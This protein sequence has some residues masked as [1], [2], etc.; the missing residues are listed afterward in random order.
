M[1]QEP[2]IRE[3]TRTVDARSDGVIRLVVPA[4]A[5]MLGMMAIS[6]VHGGRPS[7]L[8]N[9]LFTVTWTSSQPSAAGVD[10]WSEFAKTPAYEHIRAYL[11]IHE[12]IAMEIQNGVL[13]GDACWEFWAGEIHRVDDRKEKV[14]EVIEHARKEDRNEG[15]YCDLVDLSQSWEERAAKWEE[16][17]K[18]S[19]ADR[20]VTDAIPRFVKFNIMM[21]FSSKSRQPSIGWPSGIRVSFNRTLDHEI[22]PNL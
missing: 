17:A 22:G 11:N 15:M 6:F 16:K 4:L 12:L 10:N 21:S 1:A 19:E 7:P 18:K 8:T 3:F 20:M 5:L 2:S 13:D 14:I 9:L